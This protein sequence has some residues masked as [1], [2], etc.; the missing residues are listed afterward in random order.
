MAE[1]KQD[2]PQK[3]N[4]GTQQFLERALQRFKLTSEAEAE[5]RPVALEDVQFSIGKQWPSDIETNRVQEGRPC[6]V[7]NRIPQNLKLII[8]EQ[9][10]N[11]PSITV[12]PVGDGADVDTAEIEQGIIRH[13]EVNSESEIA[14][15][16]AFESMLRGGIGWMRCITKYVD[17]KSKEQEIYIQR[18]RNPFSVYHDPYAIEPDYSDMKWCFIIEDIP[19]EEY[20]AQYP[21]SDVASANL[22]EYMATGDSMA[23]WMDEKTVRVAEYYYV[24]EEM[25]DKDG[26]REVTKRTVH[27]AKFNA[28][29][30]L[31]KRDVIGDRIPMIPVLGEEVLVAG[32]LHL[33]GMVRYMKDPQRMYNYWISAATE[34][35]AL[36]PRAPFVVEAGQI[37][38]FEPE[39]RNANTRSQAVLRYKG[40]SI[41]GTMAPPPQ[42]NVYEPPV[43]AIQSMTRQ[44]DADLKYT[45]GVNAASLGDPESE[46]SGK[47][48][49]LRQKQSDLANIN[50]SDNLARSIR[51]LGRLLLSWIPV[52]YDTPRVQRI[53]HPDESVSTVITH[54]GPD[55]AQ[56]AQKLQQE[57]KAISKI[58]DLSVGRYDVTVSVGPSYQSKRQEAVASQ[59]AFIQSFPAAGPLIG[60]LVAANMDWPGAKEIAKRLKMALPPQFHDQGSTDP[61]AKLAM[62]QSQLQ[63]LGQQHQLLVQHVQDLTQ[64]IETKQVEA[65]S[66]ENIEQI[67]ASTQMQLERMKIEAQIAIAEIET[68]AQNLQERAKY[69]TDIFTELHGSAHEAAMQADQQAH[70]SDMSDKQQAMAQQQAANEQAQTQ[71]V[72]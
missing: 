23:G 17:P 46:R 60:D 52:V 57:N 62:A 27:W 34:M 38:N 11:R 63:A 2:T 3:E 55:Q 67:K 58:Y 26:E 13:I 64:Q 36:A 37:E 65:K 12:N 1:E 31:E 43:Q 14:Y 61:E 39:W 72:S 19:I 49:I 71:E 66:K 69:E 32:K 42:R 35:I 40:V 9:R 5:T 22:S 50:W 25:G 53:I 4:E 8:N 24:I 16:H 48:I 15:D 33:A 41:N 70:E 6:L 59:L 45:S 7:M 20:R 54:N 44:A 21:R 56:A 18:I 10:Q 68:K 51:S 29:E 30:I 28:K 47:A